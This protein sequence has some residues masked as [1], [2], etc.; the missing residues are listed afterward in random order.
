MTG[1]GSN[2][3]KLASKPKGD[4]CILLLLTTEGYPF[5]TNESYYSLITAVLQTQRYSEIQGAVVFDT[6]N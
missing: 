4:D 2:P 6:L 5:L 3:G 1:W